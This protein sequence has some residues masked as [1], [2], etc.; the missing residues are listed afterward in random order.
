MDMRIRL[1]AASVGI[2]HSTQTMGEK[3]EATEVKI[4]KIW[5]KHHTANL[6]LEVDLVL[7]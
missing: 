7:F 6:R 5:Y 4:S 1:Q 3:R 2:P